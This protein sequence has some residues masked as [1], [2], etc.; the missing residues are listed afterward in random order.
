MRIK[1]IGFQI[2]PLTR[3]KTVLS[4]I[5][6]HTHAYACLISRV[7]DGSRISSLVPHRISRPS[8]KGSSANSS[9]SSKTSF[10]SS[11]DLSQIRGAVL[12][13]RVEGIANSP[14]SGSASALTSAS[15]SVSTS[16]SSSPKTRTRKVASAVH[17]LSAL[18]E[19]LDQW[20]TKSKQEHHPAEDRYQVLELRDKILRIRKCITFSV[21]IA[22][23]ISHFKNMVP[24]M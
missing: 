22:K 15:A 9:D 23:K 11:L 1:F 8:P 5:H 19:L 13:D 21:L 16:S 12:R 18:Q 2:S 4:P 20:D 10:F 6:T 24:R 14:L 3:K 7:S 17:Q